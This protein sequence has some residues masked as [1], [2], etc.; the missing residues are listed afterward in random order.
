MPPIPICPDC[1]TEFIPA[2][3]DTTAPATWV[4]LLIEDIVVAQ[5]SGTSYEGCGTIVANVRVRDTKG[6]AKACVVVTVKNVGGKAAKSVRLDLFVDATYDPVVGD[7]STYYG[8]IS[9]LAAGAT[10][11]VVLSGID[12]PSSWV[13]VVVDTK[14]TVT[15]YRESNNVRTVIK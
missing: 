2:Y 11:T 15:E 6:P 5:T 10:S 8:T 14:G 7:T 9:S 12:I 13:D 1:F 3:V 4:D